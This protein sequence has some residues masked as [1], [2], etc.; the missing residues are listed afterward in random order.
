MS[1]YNI[2]NREEFTKIVE[3]AIESTPL[4]RINKDYITEN[5]KTFKNGIYFLYDKDNIVIYIGMVGDGDN[6]SFY[7]RVYGHGNGSHC[8]KEWFDEVNSFRFKSFPKLEIEELRLIERLMIYIKKQPKYNDNLM[9]VNDYEII[10]N[11][12]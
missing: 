9:I 7:H 3:K 12:L 5:C 2:M 8:K 4:V 10:K 1:E 6:T 11:K